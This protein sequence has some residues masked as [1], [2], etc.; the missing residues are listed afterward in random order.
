METDLFKLVGIVIVSFY[1]IYL[2]I[3]IFKAQSDLLEGFTSDSA[4]DSKKATTS[5]TSTTSGSLG[6]AGSAQSYAEEVK[7]NYV[8]LQD[9]LLVPK[10]RKEY[11]NIIINMD[12]YIGMLMLKQ[13]VNIN[14]N[15]DLKINIEAI[16]NLNSLKAS[17]DTLNSIMKFLDTQ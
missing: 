1:I 4:I 17:K 11:E 9:E 7:A 13:L 8:K 5:S 14:P 3:G 15:A 12:D 2:V 6:I 16:S 10:Y